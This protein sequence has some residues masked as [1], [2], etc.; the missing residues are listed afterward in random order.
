MLPL[1]RVLTLQGPALALSRPPSAAT[2]DHKLV[3]HRAETPA[4][5]LQA[6]ASGLLSANGQLGPG[7]GSISPYH[8]PSRPWRG[9]VLGAG[10]TSC[11]PPEGLGQG[12]ALRGLC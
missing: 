8:S 4:R 9:A 6:P 11:L 7:L 3:A 2:K 10:V 5:R 12:L 1:G